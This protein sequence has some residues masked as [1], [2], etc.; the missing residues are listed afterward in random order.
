MNFDGDM[1][2]TGTSAGVLFVSPEGD[3]LC[4]AFRLEFEATD[5]V[6][7]YEA[8]LL[9]LNMAKDMGIKILKIQGDSDL[10]IVQVKGQFACKNG[11]LKKYRNV[12]WDAME[13]FDVLSKE[14][15]PRMLN[16]KVDALFVVA[17]TLQPCKDLL[18]GGK[19]E[20]IFK[21]SVPDNVEHWQVFADDAQIIRFINNLQE[22]V[23]NEIDWREEGTN[24]QEQLTDNKILVGLVPLERMFD[25]HD[26]YKESLKKMISQSRVLNNVYI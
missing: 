26:M 1:S 2:R 17:S 11:R 19:L 10:V 22:F 14:A 23:K 6:V 9:G 20:I 8:L 25:R 24:Y 7:E 3:T 15:E 4:H 16:E 5:N 18:A 12:V 21:P 13:W